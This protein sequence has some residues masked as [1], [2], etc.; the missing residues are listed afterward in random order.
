MSETRIKVL[1]AD[2]HK[3]FR[4]MLYHFLSE[5]KEIE[6]LGE[7]AN[8]KEAVEKT[9]ILKPDVLLLD[10]D[11]P[12]MNGV[13]ATKIIAEKYPQTKI[14]IIT[15]MEEDEF[16]FQL[17]K[18]GASGYLLKDSSLSEVLK[19]IKA[20]HSGEALI[21]PRVVNKILR[22]LVE[23]MDKQPQPSP[24]ALKSLTGREIEVLQLAA[25]GA[26]NKEISARLF[27][28]EPTVKTHIGNIMHKLNL[29]DRV[30]MVLF[31]V[32]HQIVSPGKSGRTFPT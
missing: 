32:Q 26:N 23:L 30:E 12:E 21:Q 9:G 19:G 4:E 27:I 29:R 14:V 17:I 18:N 31:A 13:E 1:L 11:M 5:E 6:I 8:G 15:A 3:L 20:A 22:Q 24:Q 25:Q 16:I 2:D 28:S 7:A 10:I